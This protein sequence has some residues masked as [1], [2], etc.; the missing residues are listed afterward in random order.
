MGIP[1]AQLGEH[2]TLDPKVKSSILTK[3][4][5]SCVL[6]GSG[7]IHGCW[8][9]S[10]TKQLFTA[11]FSHAKKFIYTAAMHPVLKCYLQGSRFPYQNVYIHACHA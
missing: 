5:D 1:I 11:A 8:N 10:D 9:S 3:G 6:E 2:Q 7:Y 4:M